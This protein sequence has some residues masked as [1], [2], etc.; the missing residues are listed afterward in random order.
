MNIDGA[1][2]HDLLSVSGGQ[3]SQQHVDERVQLVNLRG[4]EAGERSTAVRASV[5]LRDL[6]REVREEVS[7]FFIKSNLVTGF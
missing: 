6:Q 2:R 4:G 1:D 7:S 5:W 3:L